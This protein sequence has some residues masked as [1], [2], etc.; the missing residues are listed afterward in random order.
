MNIK[1][2]IT[3][4]LLSLALAAG[5]Q[6]KPITEAYEVGMDDVRLPSS[7]TGMIAFRKCSECKFESLRVTEETVYEFNG[8]RMSLKD[9]RLAVN[10]VD[11]ALDIPV[12]VVHHLERNEITKLFVVVH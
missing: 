11:R 12:Q 10:G 1:M 8:E 4:V 5:A 2:I 6:S 9:F 7:E 3:A